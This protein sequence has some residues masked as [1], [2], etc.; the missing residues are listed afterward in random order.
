[1]PPPVAVVL[2]VTWAEARL[3]IPMKL[4][5]AV[6]FQRREVSFIRGGVIDTSGVR[7]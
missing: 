5:T 7:I 4:T 6:I 1:L 3:P 2:I